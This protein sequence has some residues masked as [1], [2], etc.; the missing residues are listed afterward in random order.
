MTAT[1]IRNT[2][3]YKHGGPVLVRPDSRGYPEAYI[4]AGEEMFRHSEL[5]DYISGYI[6]ERLH[7]R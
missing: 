5:N 2:I 6:K 1:L 7:A 3:R 4:E